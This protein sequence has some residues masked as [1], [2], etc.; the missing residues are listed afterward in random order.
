MNNTF[1]QPMSNTLKI[2]WLGS[3]LVLLVLFGF[4]FH[5]MNAVVMADEWYY[6]SVTRL[7]APGESPLPSY[8]FNALYKAGTACGTGFLDCARLL[9]SVFF[10]ASAPFIYLVGRRFLAADIASLV[11][12]LAMIGPVNSYTA[13]FM[14]ES[15]YFCTFWIM[16][17]LAFR[18]DDMPGSTH[19]AAL[20]VL[21]GALT[22]IKVHGVFLVPGLAVF[23]LYSCFR[24]KTPSNAPRWIQATTWIVLMLAV[25]AAVRLGTGYLV[26]GKSGLSLTGSLYA[27]QAGNSSG[28]QTPL[29]HLIRMSLFNL[30]GHV[31]AL[32]TLFTVPLAAL[33]THRFAR[34]MQ[35]EGAASRSPLAVYTIAVLLG[36]IGVTVMFTAFVAGNGY[37]TNFRLHMRYYNFA[38]PLLVMFGATHIHQAQQASKRLPLIIAAAIAMIVVFTIAT[39]WAPFTPSL[40]DSPEFRGMTTHHRAFLLLSALS[41]FSLG[42]WVWNRDKGARIFLFAFVPL[43]SIIASSSIHREVQAGGKSNTFDQA[44][45]YAYQYLTPQQR[46]RVAIIGTD[47]SGLFRT[48]FHIDSIRARQYNFPQNV[49]LD[50]NAMPGAQWLLLLASYPTPANAVVRMQ[51]DGFSLVELAAAQAPVIAYK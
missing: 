46:D 29:L 26:A 11:A 3:M 43:Y 40:V 2:L 48:Q 24:R 36:L 27:A 13:Y 15:L 18:F 35:T 9:N 21:L 42:V 6:S 32:T 4:R 19:A 12:L 31:F 28:Q 33:L 17:W 41:M 10:V 45:I 20:G 30:R 49:K 16:T 5:G 34:R 7:T 22:L 23:M 50:V 25:A 44:G 38:L 51:T 47:V 39:S 8:L 14:P 37:E 1:T